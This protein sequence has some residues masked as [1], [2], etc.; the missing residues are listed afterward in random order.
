[1][2]SACFHYEMGASVLAVGCV[3]VP[4]AFWGKRWTQRIHSKYGM[5]ESGALRPQN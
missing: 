2:G 1:V 4:V 3:A 5:D